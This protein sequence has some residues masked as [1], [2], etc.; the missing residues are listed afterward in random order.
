MSSILDKFILEQKVTLEEIESLNSLQKP[1]AYRFIY[2]DLP[3]DKYDTNVK[4]TDVNLDHFRDSPIFTDY[5]RFCNQIKN[6][7]TD[8]LREFIENYK[9]SWFSEKKRSA[10]LFQKCNVIKSPLSIYFSELYKLDTLYCF[11]K[12]L[13]TIAYYADS[14]L[15]RSRIES[16]TLTLYEKDAI[17]CGRFLITY[18]T[19][20]HKVSKG[21]SYKGRKILANTL[22]EIVSL[23]SYSEMLNAFK[24]ILLTK[25]YAMTN[26]YEN[27]MNLQLESFYKYKSTLS[28]VDLI[29]GYPK[30]EKYQHVEHLLLSYPEF[31]YEI[32]NSNRGEIVTIPIAVS[33]QHFNNDAKFIAGLIFGN[34]IRKLVMKQIKNEVYYCSFSIGSECLICC[35]TTD[36]ILK[37]VSCNKS[38]CCVKCLHRVD[39]KKCM[40]CRFTF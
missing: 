24:N 36:N 15:T 5:V 9:A 18:D 30:L 1:Y 37:C 6:L 3:L 31:F 23:C 11:P 13:K 29:I 16:D 33:A 28:L 38:T 10:I 14:L 8:L 19:F 12:C 4:I 26:D 32:A 20:A 39:I 35:V 25:Y 34:H 7:Q 40:L 21:Q 2:G 22:Y 17:V 27:S